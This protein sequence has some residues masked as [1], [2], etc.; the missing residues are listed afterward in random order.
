MSSEKES[1][2]ENEKRLCESSGKAGN[3]LAMSQIKSESVC[4]NIPS[5]SSPSSGGCSVEKTRKS[6]GVDESSAYL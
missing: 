1:E 2:L 3:A 6:Y 4:D 5:H